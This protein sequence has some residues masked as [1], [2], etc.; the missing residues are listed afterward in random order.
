MEEMT[1]LLTQHGLALV[2]ANVLLTQAGVPVPAV[3]I[4]IV[5]GAFVAQ[6][7]IGPASLILIAVVASLIGDTLWYFAGR[8]YGYRILRTLCRVSIEPDSCVKQ[9][10]NIFERWGAPSLLVAKFIPGFST[11]AP[12]LA[13]TMRLA[14]VPFV[15]YSAAGAAIWAGVA[16]GAGM[17][18]H[19]EVDRALAWLEQ[20]GVGVL[21]AIASILMF[22]V[23]VKWFERWM[24]IRALRL[25]RISV[26]EL[27][28]LM[29]REDRPV[30]LDV[31]SQTARKVDPRRIPGA[32]AVDINAPERVLPPV[33]P[34]RE[35]VV[36]CT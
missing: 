26:G 6:G 7:Q 27:H 21:T 8:R 29:Q 4:L 30:I 23:T 31:R 9:T 24:F 16:I 33:A 3:P 25:A 1:N 14:L 5:A 28:E 13:G 32:I 11:V 2:F 35:I 20:A 36:Y 17:V 22:Y 12:P 18:F 10:E 19:S 15:A 34:D